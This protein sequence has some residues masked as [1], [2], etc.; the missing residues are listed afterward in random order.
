MTI[1]RRWLLAAALVAWALEVAPSAQSVSFRLIDGSN[2]VRARVERIGFIAGPVLARLKDGRSMR[3]N[4]ELTIARSENS[5]PVA[6]SKSVF[7]V[8]YDLWEERFSTTLTGAVPRSASHLTAAGSEA[9]CLDQLAIRTE[10]LQS[11]GRGTLFAQVTYAV[12]DEEDLEARQDTLSLRGL[13]DRLSRRDSGNEWHGTVRSGP[14]HL[15]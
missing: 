3:V 9:W 11:V 12:R 14:V 6:S 2:F 5:P 10:T 7:Q 13:I 15:E 4:L 8:S 1:R